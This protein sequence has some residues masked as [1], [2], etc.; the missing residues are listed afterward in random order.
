MNYQTGDEKEEWPFI[1]TKGSS[2]IEH[3][4]LNWQDM[5]LQ[6]WLG[7][8]VCISLVQRQMQALGCLWQLF[9]VAKSIS[10]TQ[11]RLCI[12]QRTTNL[13]ECILRP[14]LAAYIIADGLHLLTR[15]CWG[16]LLYPAGLLRVSSN[17]TCNIL[18]IST[19][20][21]DG[22][23]YILHGACDV[24]YYTCQGHLSNI[25]IDALINTTLSL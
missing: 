11:A 9:Y 22:N 21:A 17:L 18:Q 23:R 4:V 7:L 16:F 10:Y 1:S 25:P 24:L 6:L 15:T 8:Y 2:R 5:M 13:L 3:P 20:H 14:P 12:S 19:L